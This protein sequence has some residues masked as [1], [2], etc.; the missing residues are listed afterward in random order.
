MKGNIPFNQKHLKEEIKMSHDEKIQVVVHYMAAEKP[1]K[2]DEEPSETVGQ[3]KPKVLEDFG[4]VEGQTPEGNNVVYILYH[5]KTPL[6]NPGQTLGEIAGHHKT[7]QLKL[8]QQVT[9]G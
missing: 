1:F 7:L 4:L 5:D 2:N 8:S 6:E 3:F 9:Q